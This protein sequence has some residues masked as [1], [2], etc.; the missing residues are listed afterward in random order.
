MTET[1]NSTT[2]FCKVTKI[3]KE[4]KHTFLIQIGL[5]LYML[6]IYDL[7]VEYK[8]RLERDTMALIVY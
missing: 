2:I 8:L 3:E 7:V 1:E 6:Q 4:G 5:G